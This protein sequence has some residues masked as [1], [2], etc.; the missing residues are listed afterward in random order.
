[1]YWLKCYEYNN[2]DEDNLPNT[3]IDKNQQETMLLQDVINYTEFR[4]LN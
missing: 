1:M 3:L 2:K 4:F